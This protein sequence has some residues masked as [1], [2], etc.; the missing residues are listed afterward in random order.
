MNILLLQS[1]LD[2]FIEKHQEIKTIYN[3][4]VNK[5][6]K[7]ANEHNIAD[8][9]VDVFVNGKYSFNITG[10]RALAYQFITRN[11]DKFIN[12]NLIINQYKESLN[13]TY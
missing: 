8:I 7:Y 3:K 4:Y 6:F 1:F 9:T 11:K 2:D 10:I 12:E 13:V 5:Y